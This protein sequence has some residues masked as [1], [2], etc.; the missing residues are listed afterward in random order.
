LA[1]SFAAAFGIRPKAA[2]SR[3]SMISLKNARHVACHPESS[4]FEPQETPMKIIFAA[5]GGRCTDKATEFLAAHNSLLEQGGEVVVVNVQLEMPVRVRAMVGDD[6]VHNYYHEESQ[7][8]L[9]PISEKLDHHQIR[10]RC[11]SATGSIAVEVVAA[12]HREQADLILMGTHG[13]GPLG[14]AL[15]GSVAQKVLVASDIP[16]LLV[17]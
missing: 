15:M 14:R 13:H 5:D 2:G 9:K 10:H 7:K 4:N 16:V 12:A 3:A 17:K 6:F 8:I 1:P 11:Q